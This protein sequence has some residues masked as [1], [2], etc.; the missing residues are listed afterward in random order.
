LF[1]QQGLLLVKLLNKYAEAGGGGIK[2]DEEY[3]AVLQPLPAPALSQVNGCSMVATSLTRNHHLF[4]VVQ[5][6]ATV[7]ALLLLT[8]SLFPS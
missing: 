1:S 3:A 8:Y 2:I 5:G 4:E 6:A 7:L